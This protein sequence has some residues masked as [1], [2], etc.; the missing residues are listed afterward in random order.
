[1]SKRGLT[2]DRATKK[3]I[4]VLAGEDSNDRKALGILIEAMC[5]Y[6]RGRIVEINGTVRLRDAPDH[7]LPQRAAALAGKISARAMRERAEIACVFV[8]EDFDAVDSTKRDAVRRRV[9]FALRRH[10]SRSY[11]I[12]VPWETEAWLLLFPD[13]ITAIRSAWVVPSR[14]RKTDTGLVADPKRVMRTEVS[15]A[16]SR[17]QEGDAP[18]ILEKAVELGLHESPSGTNRSYDEL[19]DSVD[20]CCGSL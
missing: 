15:D 8:H 11:Y 19:R 14:R 16:G 17:Y 13:A 18:R 12:L 9:Q 5:P 7:A 3:P 4:I 1:M 10:I 6:T 20:E 2:S